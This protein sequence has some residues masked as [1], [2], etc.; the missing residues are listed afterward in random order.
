MPAGVPPGIRSVVLA[1]L[2]I[3][4]SVLAIAISL[5]WL[6]GLLCGQRR[7]EYITGITQQAMSAIVGIFHGTAA[8][9]LSPETTE[10]LATGVEATN[11][12]MRHS[13]RPAPPT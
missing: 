8:A 5:L 9:P 7:R 3:P 13:G 4:A 11:R 10:T 2:A 1:V 6:L 12:P